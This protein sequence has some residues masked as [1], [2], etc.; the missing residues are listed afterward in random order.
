MRDSKDYY[1]LLGLSRSATDGEIK[2]AYRKMARTYHPDVNPGDP[3]SESKFKQVNEAYKVLSDSKSKNAY[4][5]FG[6]RWKEAISAENAG[7]ATYAHSGF[8]GQSPFNFAAGQDL[9]D[10]LGGFF[11]RTSRG[12]KVNLGDSVASRKV[13]TEISISL[14]EAYEGTTRKL[15]VPPNPITGEQNRPVDLVIPAGVKSGHRMSGITS[16]ST[17][18]DLT[19]TVRIATDKQ[20]ERRGDNLEYIAE[21]SLVDAILGGEVTIPTLDGGPVALTIPAETQNGRTFK[22]SGRGMTKM[23]GGKGDFLVRIKVML[24]EQLT[25]EERAL[26]VRLKE[27]RN[28]MED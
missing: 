15:Q 13:K 12:R 3:K 23:T 21:V 19:V 26:F 4:D 2:A 16:K 8:S 10:V 6:S 27:A 5:R 25:D 7:N 22:L 20:F 14:K 18:V 28:K 1:N 9:S 17:M 24:P 11:G